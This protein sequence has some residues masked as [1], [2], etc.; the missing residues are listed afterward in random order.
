[1]DE[2]LHQQSPTSA[3]PAQSSSTGSYQKRRT[4]HI[5]QAP[6]ND[7]EPSYV[8]RNE[9]QTLEQLN[10]RRRHMGVATNDPD[11]LSE[12]PLS[13]KQRE[14]ERAQQHKGQRAQQVLTNSAR[15]LQTP[16]P[17][18]SIFISTQVKRKRQRRHLFMVLFALIFIALITC[19]LLFK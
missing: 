7:V 17:G 13:Q 19:V 14:H 1:M 2:Q 9:Y 18:R 11:Y 3:D 4:H 10:E 6:I 16:K 8:T 5:T 15:Y 12:A